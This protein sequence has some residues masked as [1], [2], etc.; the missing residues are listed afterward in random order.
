M[1]VTINGYSDITSWYDI[2]EATTIAIAMCIRNGNEAKVVGIGT[3]YWRSC[4]DCKIQRL[5]LRI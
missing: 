3:R 4:K 5:I 2:W 1:T